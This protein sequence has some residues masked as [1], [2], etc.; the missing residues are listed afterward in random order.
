M[1][2]DLGRRA[3]VRTVTSTIKVF[4]QPD[5]TDATV[6]ADSPHEENTLA[7]ASG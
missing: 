2:L 7:Y 5:L 1:K 6:H 3:V 4:L